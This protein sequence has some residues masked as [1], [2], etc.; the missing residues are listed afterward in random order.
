ME[1][2]C[3]TFGSPT[4]LAF[5]IIKLQCTVASANRSAMHTAEICAHMQTQ[6]SEQAKTG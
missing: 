4:L 2:N 1:R 5:Q 3:E 6:P